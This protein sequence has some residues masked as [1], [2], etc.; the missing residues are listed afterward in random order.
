MKMAKSPYQH[1]A[2]RDT[3]WIGKGIGSPWWTFI[4]IVLIAGAIAYLVGG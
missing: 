2:T 4:A 1:D 3:H